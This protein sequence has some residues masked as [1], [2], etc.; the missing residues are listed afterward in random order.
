MK[1]IVGVYCIRNLINNKRYIGQTVNAWRRFND[2]ISSLNRGDH[3]NFHLQQSWNKYGEK[4]FDFSVLEACEVSVLDEK[5]RYYISLHKTMDYNLGYNQDGGGN[6]GK[7]MSKSTREKISSSRQGRDTMSKGAKERLAERMKGNKLRLGLPMP[8]KAK[9]KLIESHKGNKY[10][11]GRKCTDEERKRMSEQ[12]KGRKLPSRKGKVSDETR[13]KISE[14]LKNS[15]NRVFNFANT[16]T[17]EA[18]AKRS[19][20]LK[21]T[22]QKRKEEKKA[23]ESN[24]L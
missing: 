21:R 24:L 14:A 5:E 15:K 17:P 3:K 18:N 22:W 23:E 10:T 2:H 1:A 7:V 4:S 6:R 8:E 9:G 19:E 12:R 16:R 13:K 11:L 20:S